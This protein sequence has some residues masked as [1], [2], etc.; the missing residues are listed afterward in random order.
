MT[1]REEAESL[2]QGVG[3][4][5]AEQLLELD[6]YVFEQFCA[7]IAKGDVLG[8][9][10]W[11]F[12][13][14]IRVAERL[15]DGLEALIDSSDTQLEHAEIELEELEDRA[16]E[17]ESDEDWDAYDE[18]RVFQRTW[19]PK[20]NTF[21]RKVAKRLR[22]ARRQLRELER[23]DNRSGEEERLRGAIFDHYNALAD[24][25]VRDLWVWGC[26]VELWEVIGID[27]DA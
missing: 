9:E 24:V 20:I 3:F 2:I 25:D 14:D 4:E 21:K 17:T 1:T 11:L 22:A 5:T 27:V 16:Q 18:L 6:D 8:N 10:A 12:E 26:C 13:N 15:V 19:K 7:R 23:S